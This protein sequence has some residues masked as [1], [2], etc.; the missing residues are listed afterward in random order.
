[1]STAEELAFDAALADLERRVPTRMLPDLE[2]ITA[3]ADLMGDPQRSYPSIHITGTNGKTSVARMTTA[4]LSALGVATGTYTSPHL[5]SIRERLSVAGRPIDEWRFGEVHAELAPLVGLVDADR[6]DPDDHVTYFELLTAM[7]YWWFADLPVEVGVFEVGMGGTWDATNLVRG[8]VAVLTTIDVDHRELGATPAEVA[9]E[10]VGIIK[11][12]ATVVSGQQA[13]DVM[14]IVRDAAAAAGAGVLVAGEDFD[15]LERRV[16]VGGQVVTLRVGDRVVRELVL[17]LFGAYQA[18]NAAVALAAF[19]AFHR[20]GFA[21]LA[22]EVIRD[23]LGAVRT[24]GRLEVVSRDPTVLLDGAHNP[25]GARATAA[26]V[27]EAFTFRNLVLVAACL[28]DKD[29]AGILAPFAEIANH[30]VVTA[31]PSARG[32]SAAE[33]S[34]AARTTWSGSGVIVEVADDL[35]RALDMATGVAGEGDGVLVTGS[36]YTVGA[37]R[38]RYAPLSS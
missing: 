1:M 2:R 18:T 28:Q 13:A 17:P 35:E 12:G 24:P 11:P 16:A 36:L 37:A 34:A 30:V 9:R 31:A 6:P 21:D 20:D 7:A 25:H 33:M 15:V 32:A 3:L 19:A 38:D 14:R 4:L 26:A 22:D 27:E 5:Q 8:D 23:A 29:I 10:K